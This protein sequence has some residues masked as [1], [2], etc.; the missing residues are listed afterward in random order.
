MEIC[1]QFIRDFLQP[2]FGTETT[3]K[4]NANV[5]WNAIVHITSHDFQ[6]VWQSLPQRAWWSSLR[7]RTHPCKRVSPPTHR[8]PVSSHGEDSSSFRWWSGKPG[9]SLL[10]PE[11]QTSVS[12]FA[13][14][15]F[16]MFAL[17]QHQSG[18]NPSVHLCESAEQTIFDLPKERP[19][20]PGLFMS[21]HHKIQFV[22]HCANRRI[23]LQTWQL[24]VCVFGLQ[25]TQMCAN[26]CISKEMWLK[27]SLTF[28]IILMPLSSSSVMS[29]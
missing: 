29:L 12:F 23:H 28:S 2:N 13:P 27:G 11:N 5:T 25:Q 8:C 4:L 9:F 15:R 26:S 16:L 24:F 22:H 6:S 18:R 17:H 7:R 3:C 14:D 1:Q 19:L 20:M 10:G 21:K